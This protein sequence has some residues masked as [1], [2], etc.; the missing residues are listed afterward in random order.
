MLLRA[1]NQ[2]SVF[3]VMPNY[4]VSKFDA[5]LSFH[6]ENEVSSLFVAFFQ[7]KKDGK[8][9]KNKN[10]RAIFCVAIARSEMLLFLSFLKADDALL[11]LAR[12]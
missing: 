12:V 1:P 6:S 10:K 5:F 11:K 7:R 9:V 8:V 4:S 3:Y 2:I